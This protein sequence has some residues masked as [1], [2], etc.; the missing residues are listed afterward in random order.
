M[1]FGKDFCWCHKGCLAAAGYGKQHGGGGHHRLAATNL[2]LKQA[3]HGLILSQV[4]S[5]IVQDSPL[6]GGQL[7]GQRDQESCQIF[8]FCIQ[9]DPLLRL[10][11]VSLPG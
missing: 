5:D 7:K 11:P 2:P 3:T 6:S 1:L 4:P 10:P 9:A 8:W